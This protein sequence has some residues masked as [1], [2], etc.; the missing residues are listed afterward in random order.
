MIYLVPLIICLLGHYLYDRPK[1]RKKGM[2]LWVVL[3]LVLVLMMGL[4]YKVVGDTYNYMNFFQWIPDISGWTLLNA[5]GFEPGFSLLSSLIKTVSDSIYVYQTVLSALMT[6]LLMRFVFRNTRFPYLAMLLVYVAMYLY[7]STEIMRES[8]AVVGLLTCYPLLQRKKYLPY[9]LV[10]LLLCTFHVSAVICFFIPFARFLHFDRRLIPYLA[11]VLVFSLLFV[12]VMERLAG[13][14]VFE[15]LAIYVHQQNV[16]YAWTGLRFIYFAL[17]PMLVLYICKIRYRIPVRFEGIICLQ[18]LF[19]LSLWSVP[20]VFQRL[21]NYT[22]IFYLVSAA[23]MMGTLLRDRY[24]FR[25]TSRRAFKARKLL[26]RTL[27]ALTLVAHSSYYIHLQFYQLF[28]PY[29]SV[30][31]PVDV[32]EREKFVQGGDD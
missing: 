21:I 7:F 24:F 16:G 23:E 31:D 13:I 28:L 6:G 32:P 26:S 1:G 4:R 10:V 20:I 17:I 25:N 8:L 2:G 12:P 19:G 15:R 18:I 14:P 9:C 27:V 29:H 22:I 3:Y 11:V 30:F 5:A